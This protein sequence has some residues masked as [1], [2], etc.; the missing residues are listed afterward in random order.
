MIASSVVLFYIGISF[1]FFL[2]LPMVFKFFIYI[3]PASVEVK[4]DMGQYFSFIVRVLL[5]FGFSFEV[6]IAVILLVATGLASYQ[7]LASMRPYIIVL[8]F[9]VGM[10]LTPP[11]I[12]SQIMLAIPLWLLYELGL[13]LSRIIVKTKQEDSST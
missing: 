13:W 8:A 6:P 12:V 5:A 2:V 7:K 1:A 9:V 10:V 11:D 4:P 3:A